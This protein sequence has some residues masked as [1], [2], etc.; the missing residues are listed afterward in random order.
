MDKFIV[1]GGNRLNGEITLH[2]AKNAVLPLLSCCLLCEEEVV[3][4][5]CQPLSDVKKMTEIIVRMGGK[6]YFENDDLHVDCSNAEFMPID[7]ELTKSI[8]S[9]IFMLGSLLGRFGK[10]EVS[11]PGG[12][13]IGKRPIDIHIAGLQKLGV[14]I[15]ET[16]KY[17]VCDGKNLHSGIINLSMPSVGATE[18]MIMAAVLTKGSTVINN[19][20]KEPEIID[21]QNF[22]N[23]LGGKVKGAGGDTII[24]EGVERLHGCKYRPVSDRIAAGTYLT[25]CAACGGE[26]VLNNCDIKGLRSVID[27][28]KSCGCR[29]SEEG[30][31]L[32]L[33]SDGK[34]RNA[35]LLRTGPFP[36]F[37]TDMQPQVCA[38]LSVADGVSLI[39]E[40]VFENRF[41]YVSQLEIM[42]ADIA[43]DGRRALITGVSRL[44]ANI[45][46][47]EDLRGGAALVTAAL[48]ADGVSTVYGVEHIDRGYYKI[49]DELTRLGADIVR[50]S[51]KLFQKR[52]TIA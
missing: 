36:A 38:L 27:V 19:A 29:I 39:E 18:N 31:L 51:N 32:R 45:I 25:M 15:A 26:I 17:I 34:L 52:K 22:I 28:L 40:T 37:P 33:S 3:L 2:A 43:L 42:G 10:A 14:K 49:E 7:A 4:R 9:S 24:V 11:Y 50:V 8:R 48:M 41:K 1:M 20:A 47:A 46:E 23:A 30:D 6:A 35:A 12:C 21:L 44:H 16:E 5:D 13:E